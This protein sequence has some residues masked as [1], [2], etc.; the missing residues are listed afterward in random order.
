MLG[1]EYTINP[2]MLMKIVGSIFAVFWENVNFNFFFLCDLPL[3]MK[4][5]GKRRKQAEDICKRTLDIECERDSPVGL[6][7]KLDDEQKIK[8]IFSS[9]RDFSG[10]SR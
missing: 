4:A 7:A 10:K 2:Q 5:D 6:G 3:I 1:T 8:N 9:F